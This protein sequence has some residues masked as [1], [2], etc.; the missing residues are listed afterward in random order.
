MRVEKTHWSAQNFKYYVNDSQHHFFAPDPATATDVVLH[1]DR[2]GEPGALEYRLRHA[3]RG[4][5]CAGQ[6]RAAAPGLPAHASGGLA[7][8]AS[9]WYPRTTSERIPA[10]RLA[11]LVHLLMRRVRRTGYNARVH[12]LKCV[13]WR[14][15][16]AARLQGSR[17]IHLAR[18]P[19]PPTVPLTSR[20]AAETGT[21]TDAGT[22]WEAGSTKS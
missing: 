7:I 14:A 1:V 3:R 16:D 9:G 5:N 8:V 2:D 4:C 6:W 18:Q 10:T 11:I 12:L 21:C 20:H 13:T 17:A 19:L 22:R 15:R